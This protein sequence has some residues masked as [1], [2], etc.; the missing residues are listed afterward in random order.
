MAPITRHTAALAVC[1]VVFGCGKRDV[2]AIHG[3]VTCQGQPVEVGLI[4][5][6]PIADS[7]GP[8]S[9]GTIA[10]GRYN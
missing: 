5:F 1:F 9:R 2:V 8:V 3:T 10:T 7:S 4:S 6:M